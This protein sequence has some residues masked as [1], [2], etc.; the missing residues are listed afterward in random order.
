MVGM[1]TMADS[2]KYDRLPD[3]VRRE[4]DLAAAVSRER[5]LDA[6]V[7]QALELIDQARAKL[8][9]LRAL[10]IYLWLH[11]MTEVE[12]QILGHRV[13]VMLGQRIG[14]AA[15]EDEESDDP[16]EEAPWGE[17]PSSLVRQVRK[18]LHGRVNPELR[19]WVELHT[20]RTEVALL[21]VHVAN[22]LRFIEILN[23]ATS[24]TG[25]VD[26]YLQLLS[27][28]PPLGTMIYFFVLDRLSMPAPDA[29]GRGAAGPN[30]RGSASRKR[31]LRILDSSS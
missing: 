15:R 14:A 26:L 4:I 17:E 7:L 27:I 16:L 24:Y 12:A 6:H 1:K 13:L 5:L 2:F 3:S 19:R 8:A 18:R 21:E 10:N 9:P 25:A 11:S 22:A 23:P 29:S 20:G 28:P 30:A 31:S